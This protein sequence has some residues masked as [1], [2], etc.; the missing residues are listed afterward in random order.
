M[1]YTL[2]KDI[3]RQLSQKDALNREEESILQRVSSALS[4][5]TNP[6]DRA[7]LRPDE[8]LVRICPA[9]HQPVLV[10]YTGDGE[11]ECIHNTTTHF[12]LLDVKD[13]LNENITKQCEH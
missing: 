4:T 1:I 6:L 2:L 13:W 5:L 11:C 9:T 3:Q 8:I 12:D 7:L 10:C